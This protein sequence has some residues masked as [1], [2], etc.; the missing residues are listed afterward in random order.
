LVWFQYGGDTYILQ[1]ENTGDQTSG[2]DTT[3]IVVKVV[4]INDVTSVSSGVVTIA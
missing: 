1:S 4:G 3:D 2:V